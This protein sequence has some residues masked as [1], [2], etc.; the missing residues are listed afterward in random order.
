MKKLIT[1]GLEK[2]GIEYTE[3]QVELLLLYYNEISLWNRKLGL[4]NAEGEK[5]VV[6]HILDS[7]SGVNLL[8]KYD[9]KTAADAGSGAGLPGIPLSVFFPDK[10]F[11]LIERSGNRCGFLRNCKE[12]FHLDNIEVAESGLENIS[13]HYDVI[14]F[15]A[16]RD[17]TE[18]S[19]ILIDKLTDTGIL[20]AYKGKESEIRKELNTSG[21]N[22][23]K[24]EEVEVPFL[25]EERHIVIV[26]KQ[27]IS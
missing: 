3:K 2:S 19:D 7:L 18:Y 23:F 21:I 26:G 9:F 20:F 15:R 17:F 24:I 8:K 13:D 25:N 5:L 12:L 11:T 27:N 22:S 16:F 10:K 6:N 14:T 1:E 4:V